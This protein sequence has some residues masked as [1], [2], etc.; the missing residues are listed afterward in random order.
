MERVLGF[1]KVTNRTD[2]KNEVDK[3]PF[4]DKNLIKKSSCAEVFHVTKRLTTLL[5]INVHK[6]GYL[7]K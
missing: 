2:K 6:N 1:T 5:I 4:F 7:K 3:K